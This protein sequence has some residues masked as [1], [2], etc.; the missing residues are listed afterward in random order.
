VVLYRA[1]GPRHFRENASSMPPRWQA[2]HHVRFPSLG[3][4]SAT[5]S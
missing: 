3:S 2:E 4:T 5:R 1:A